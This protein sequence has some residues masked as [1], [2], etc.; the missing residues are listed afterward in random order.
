M[1]PQAAFYVGAKSLDLRYHACIQVP[2]RFEPSPI[3]IGFYLFVFVV[4]FLMLELNTVPMKSFLPSQNN[5]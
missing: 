2:L 4:V 1:Q 5:E 3:S